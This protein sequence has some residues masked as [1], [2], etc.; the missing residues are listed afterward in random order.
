MASSTKQRVMD[1]GALHDQAGRLRDPGYA[2]REVRRYDRA[3]I[4]ADPVRIK[5]WD[6]YCIL[7][8]DCGLALTVADNGY[9]GFLGVSWMD[10]RRK[11]FVNHGAL[12]PEPMGRMVL[13]ASADSGDIVQVQQG[14]ELA[15][16]HERGGRRLTVHAPDFGDGV[17]LSGEV[18][19]DQPAMD[20][21]VIATPFPDDPHAFYYNQKINC[22]PAS[23]RVKVGG[24]YHDFTPEK[25]FAVL[26][27][28]RGVWTYDNIWYWG[29]ASGMVDGRSFG[30]NIGY[31][32]GDTS[33]ASENMLFVD[34]RAHKLDQVTFHLPDGALDA[35]PWRFS[36]NDGRF[37]LGF[38]PAVNRWDKVDA[39]LVKTEQD[40]LFGWYSGTVLLD[41][42]TP[43]AV[44]D[45][46]GFAEKVWNR[47]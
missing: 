17:G 15:F 29:S 25:A 30:F 2:T 22:M 39:G 37:E 43:L 40:Q 19:L 27:W 41:D 33:A 35:S 24:E 6:Y 28:G 16:R 1:E 20:R 45:L 18:W 7:D 47:W 26:D 12:V 23:G 4:A 11:S 21:M 44:R 9:V 10:L 42:G 34:G 31:G 32:F 36:S 46:P 8:A 13:P 38:R 3:A 5:E 14:V